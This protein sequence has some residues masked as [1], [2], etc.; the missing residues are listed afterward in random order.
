[1][2]R[3]GK[4]MELELDVLTVHDQDGNPIVDYCPCGGA[5]YHKLCLEADLEVS[6]TRDEYY[7]TRE[8]FGQALSHAAA[9][10]AAQ[11]VKN[12][13]PEEKGHGSA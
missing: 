11:R 3:I 12:A 6:A 9:I 1:M 2:T 10:Y 13:Q 5:L 4:W 8:E 7:K